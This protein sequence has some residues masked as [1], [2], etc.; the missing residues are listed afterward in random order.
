MMAALTL[1]TALYVSG[2][3]FRAEVRTF[4]TAKN[5]GLPSD[6]V[7]DI[8]IDSTGRV[9]AVTAAGAALWQNGKWNPSTVEKRAA[10]SK[11]E[12]RKDG[13]FQRNAKGGWERLFPSDG[14]RSWAPVDVRG[15]A[16]DSKGRLWFASPQGAGVQDPATG[17]WTLYTGADGLPYDDFTCVAPGED[18][19]VWFGTKIGAIRFDG[20][21]WEYRQG[22]RWLPNDE[23]RA[24]AVEPTSGNAW[25]A[26]AGGVSL[27]ERKPM[28]LAEKAR[29]FEAEIDK[30]HRRTPYEYV[31]PVVLKN[32][33]DLS[34]WTQTDSD[35][36]GLWTSMYG[37]G[38]CYSY[39]ATGSEISRKRARKAFEAMRFLRIVTQGG[40]HPA[41]PG[42]LA[43]SILPVSGGRD[44]NL[45]DSLERDIHR[46]KN[47]ERRWKVLSPRWPKSADG[48]WYWKTDTSSDELDGHYFF[49]GLYYDLVA[50]DDEQEKQRVREHV[51]AV[52]DHLVVHNYTLVDHDGKPTRW[53]VFNPEEINHNRDWW[54]ERGM[55]SLSILAYLK[56]AEHITGDQ[57]Y[58][59]AARTLIDVHGY[60]MNAMIVKSHLGQGAGNQ[61]DDE[62]IFM[63]YY[64]LLRYEK[65]P[66]LRQKYLR[67]FRSHWENER[68]EMNPVFHFLYAAIATGE[69]FEDAYGKDDLTPAKSSAWL[70]DSVETLRRLPLDRVDW[71]LKNSHRKDVVRLPEDLRERGDAVGLRV[72]GKVLPIDERFV[73]HWNHDPWRLDHR[74]SSGKTLGDG[75]IYL[76]P[77]YMGLY[78]G[79]LN[80]RD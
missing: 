72:N 35:N 43:R 31:H 78:H 27:I 55:N 6:D 53:G 1:A 2:Q 61:S 62:M 47:I 44:P 16:N 63:N 26:T 79:F 69:L 36:D 51:A 11:V 32:P 29:I 40:E 21:S 38:E 56:V 30:R 64:S 50:K 73:G 49:Y 8:R 37:A 70:E 77:Y 14:V 59:K 52:T 13:L 45:H 39:A 76:L 42:F 75:A 15:V 41:P 7:T 80:P 74:G 65:D 33:G 25:I 4:Y 24:I 23:V 68:A 66:D 58:A 10:L 19:V 54:Q 28:T 18:G 5:S 9:T 3:T 17:K 57:R 67:G 12:G 34:D 20:K 48:Q 46:Q 60:A 71:P 22:L